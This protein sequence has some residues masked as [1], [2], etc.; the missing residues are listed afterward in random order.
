[1]LGK[2]GNQNPTG[3]LLKLEVSWKSNVVCFDSSKMKK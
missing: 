1:M 3:A 2:L